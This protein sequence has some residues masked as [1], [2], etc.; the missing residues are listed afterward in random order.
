MF[1]VSEAAQALNLRRGLEETKKVQINR[2]VICPISALLTYVSL[3]LS[4][5]GL[6]DGATSAIVDNMKMD[7]V[8]KIDILRCYCNLYTN[9]RQLHKPYKDN[10]P[11]EST[12]AN[13]PKYEVQWGRA[14]AHIMVFAAWSSASVDYINFQAEVARDFVEVP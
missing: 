8:C 3:L 13:G 1:F 6:F 10:V 11:N 7:T 14:L 9:Y 5:V 4:C 2:D 12:N